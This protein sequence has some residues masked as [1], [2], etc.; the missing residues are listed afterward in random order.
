MRSLAPHSKS[1]SQFS[2]H[3]KR[4]PDFI[5]ELDGFD[6]GC[7]A[8]AK[9]GVTVRVERQP[10]AG[11]S[12]R[13]RFLRAGVVTATSL[14]R[15]CPGRLEP[16]RSRIFAPG[17]GDVAQISLST[18]LR[19]D[20]NTAGK[21]FNRHFVQTLVLLVSNPAESFIERFRHVAEGVLH[22]HLL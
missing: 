4:Q 15:S 7:I 3:D 18:E 13:A 10:H 8:P 19:G 14:R 17:T 6:N 2:Q 20:A 12:P 1:G 22:M 16:C 5:G 11:A 21:G 9:V